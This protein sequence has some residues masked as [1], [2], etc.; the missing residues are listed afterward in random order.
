MTENYKELFNILENAHF[1]Y[2][3]AEDGR[4]HLSVPDMLTIQKEYDAQEMKLK[5]LATAILHVT[6]APS[7]FLNRL[8]PK[9]DWSHE[10]LFKKSKKDNKLKSRDLIITRNKYITGPIFNELNQAFGLQLYQYEYIFRIKNPEVIQEPN[11]L[12]RFKLPKINELDGAYH[13]INEIKRP[14]I[15]TAE[16]ISNEHFD[17]Q[18]T[19]SQLK[20]RYDKIFGAE[21]VTVEKKFY[22]CYS[23][24]KFDKHWATRFDNWENDFWS[25]IHDALRSTGISASREKHCIGIDFNWQEES[26]LDI[27]KEISHLCP[28]ANISF[29]NNH[30]CKFTIA[31]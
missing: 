5:P 22:Y 18:L 23:A 15:Q 1:E 8:Y 25:Q 21:N 11:L 3:I 12:K 17:I 6:P 7:F 2:E 4:L 19:Y 28:M 16:T 20:E 26:F 31:A 24:E 27:L 13:H 14:R 29:Y 30:K 9:I 10:T